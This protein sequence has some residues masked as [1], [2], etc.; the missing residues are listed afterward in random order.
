MKDFYDIYYLSR[1]YHFDGAKLQAALFETLQRR[2]TSYDKDSF[3]RIVVLAGDADMKK[4][5][6]FF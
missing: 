3:K 2:G 6:K 4:R 5:W 1:T